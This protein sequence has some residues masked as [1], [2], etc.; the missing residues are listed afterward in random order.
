MGEKALEDP[1]VE[2]FHLQ[3]AEPTFDKI[4]RMPIAD[5]SKLKAGDYRNQIYAFITQ[6]KKQAIEEGRVSISANQRKASKQSCASSGSL[7]DGTMPM[8]W[9]HEGGAAAPPTTPR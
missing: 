8:G 2:K 7:G 5:T 6:R 3:E 4:I 9:S 1:F